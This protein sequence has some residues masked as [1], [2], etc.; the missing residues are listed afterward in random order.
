[1]F[2][3]RLLSLYFSAP[4]SSALCS[5]IK[6]RLALTIK[7]CL[8]QQTK[9]KCLG[10][11]I[12]V[13]VFLFVCLLVGATNHSSCCTSDSAETCSITGKECEPVDSDIE[14]T[15]FPCS[16]SVPFNQDC[17]TYDLWEGEASEVTEPKQER[18]TVFSLMKSHDTGS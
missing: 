1:M 13:A 11:F 18:N 17:L 5:R 2:R 12:F 14:A 7:H 16:H 4:D 9:T 6:K 8:Q 10:S 15:L 3:D